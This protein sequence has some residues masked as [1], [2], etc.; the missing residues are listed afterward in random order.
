MEVLTIKKDIEVLKKFFPGLEELRTLTMP[1][2]VGMV[3]LPELLS[4][5]RDIRE[6]Y[7]LHVRVVYPTSFPSETIT[8][9]DHFRKIDWSRI[10]EKHRHY[11]TH[12]GSLCTH[13]SLEIN[14]VKLENRSFMIV[15]NAVRL[16]NAYSFYL[17]TGQWILED[18]PHGYE[19]AR[20]EILRGSEKRF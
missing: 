5:P 19:A 2:L 13:H 18:L 3:G 7:S 8:V 14:K 6:K 11:H 12:D 20:R 17:S 9:F 10:P 16:F 1:T 4:V 15:L